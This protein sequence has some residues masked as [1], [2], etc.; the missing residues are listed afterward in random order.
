[1]NQA[2]DLLTGSDLYKYDTSKSFRQNNP[3]A[4]ADYVAGCATGGNCAAL[5]GF[6]YQDSTTTVTFSDGAFHVTTTETGSRI[7]HTVD[8][9]VGGSGS[10]GGGGSNVSPVYDDEVED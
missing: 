1:M 8:I 3:E 10:S 4:R 5:D 7:P 2:I 6:K 9:P